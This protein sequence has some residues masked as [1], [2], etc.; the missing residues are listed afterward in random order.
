MT[1]TL[2]IDASGDLVLNSRKQ[3]VMLTGTEKAVQDIAVILKS[4]VG[5]YHLNTNFGTDHIAM[6]ESRQNLQAIQN[7]VRNALASYSA[8]TL[9]TVACSYDDN[10]ALTIAISGMLDTGDPVSLEVTL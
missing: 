6:I 10:R 2:K 1:K 3:L 9:D 8:L 5:S 7:E 4:L